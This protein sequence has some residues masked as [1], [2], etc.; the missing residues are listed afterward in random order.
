M[1]P[2]MFAPVKCYQN[3]MLNKKVRRKYRLAERVKAFCALFL[4]LTYLIGNNQF[5]AFHKLLHKNEGR[6]VTHSAEQEKDRCHRTIYHYEK[7][8]CEHRSHLTAIEKCNVC[9]LVFHTDQVTIS[10]TPEA[11]IKT[12]SIIIECPVSAQL[13]DIVISYPSRGPPTV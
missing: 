7:N 2:V 10:H 8:K 9:H 3:S 13:A 1:L 11:F 5:A 6:L 12:Y 4:L